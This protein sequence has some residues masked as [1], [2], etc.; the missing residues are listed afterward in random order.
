MQEADKTKEQ[1][2]TEVAQLRQRI[3]ELEQSEIER[4]RVEEALKEKESEENFRALAENAADGI[5]ILTSEGTH[6]YVNRRAAEIV[7]YTVDELLQVGFQNLFPQDERKRLVKM[8][9]KKL[10]RESDTAKYETVIIRKDGKRVPLEVSSAL[11][12]WHGESADIVFSRDITERKQA[13]EALQESE[14]RYRNIFETIPVSIIVLDK[15]GQMVDINPYHLTQ[16]AK[17]QIPKGDFIGK[18]IV[19]HPTI[20]KSG[21]SETYKKVLKGEPFDHKDVYFPLL[22]TG[23]DGYFNVRGVPLLKDD[24]V[25]GAIIIHEDITERKWMEEALRES[26]ERYRTLIDNIDVGINLMDADHS[27]LMANAFMGKMFNKPVSELIG[28]K[29]FLEFEKR[30]AVC[31]HCPGVQTMATGKPAE[32]ET[33][34]VRDD[35]SRFDVR[36]QAFPVTGQDGKTTAFIEIAE[37]I[38]E[39]K[40]M[41]G[42]LQESEEKFRSMFELLPYSTVLLDAEGNI[43]ACNQQFVRFHAT[44]EG[45]EAQVGRNISDFFPP[46]EKSIL[47]V[48]IEKTIKEKKNV[49]GPVEYTMLREDGSRF[50]AEGFSVVMEDET[51]LPK[52]V[53][54]LA[55]DITKRKQAAKALRESE[56]KYRSL[57]ESSADSIYLV[58]RDCTYLFMNKKHLSRLGVKNSRVIGKAYGEFHSPEET[59]DFS[60]KVEKVFKT[61]KSLSYEYRSERDNKYF[62]RTLSPVKASEGGNLSAVTVISKDITELK[63][64]EEMLR[65]RE[66]FNFALFHYNPVET[67]VVDLEGKATGFNLAKE[68]SGDRLPAIGDMMYKDYAGKHEIDMHAELMICIK[69]GK[70]K[71]FPE[72][73]YGD[74]Y[75][76]ITISPFSQGALI[77]SED[78]TERKRAEELLQRERD[79]FFSVLQKAPYGAI[80]IDKEGKGI[81]SN[82]EFTNIT[83]YTLKDVSTLKD[84]FRLA[85]PDKKYRDMVIHTLRGD[86]VQVDGDK[87]YQKEFH[88]AFF[89]TFTMTCKDGT[90]KEI[91]FRPTMLEDGSTIVMLADITE[92][93]RMH[94]LVEAAATEWRTTFDAIS[95]AVC[96]LDQKGSIKRCNNAMLRMIGKPFSEI[97]DR[98]CWEVLHGV[99]NPP[100]G[101]PIVRVQETHHRETDVFSKDNRWFNISVD[102]LMDDEGNLMGGVH[103]MSDITER[104]RVEDELQSSRKQL[105]NLT[106]YLESVREQERTVIARE[107]HDELAQ[108]L[109]ALKMDLSWL[110]NRLP[111]DQNSLLDK[112]KSMNSLIDT[113][114]KTVK[115]ISAELR[116]GILDDLGLVAAIEWQAEEFQERTGIVCHITADP[117]DMIVDQD[118]STA[119]FRIFQETL[120]NVARHA[121]ATRVTVILKE[122]TRALTLSVRD[123]GKG[124][125]EEQ[126]ADS[127]S[128]GLIGMRERV[129]PWGGK[130]TIKGTPGKGTAVLVSV[131][132]EKG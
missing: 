110:D 37:D 132:V 24:V 77:I 40:Q 21:L 27:I 47:F 62:I 75:L 109:T 115:R 60:H 59:K 22:T 3:A 46:E 125:T 41:E 52:A 5:V 38:T 93:K 85:Y 33:K 44:R 82:I 15:D 29:C 112:T 96:L 18:N 11:T 114:I 6:A 19:T 99:S 50:P 120:T 49:I 92:R 57:V 122:K 104:K 53:L 36:L 105:R 9:R 86:A 94:D 106:T 97:V 23:T 58:D 67:I 70:A 118:R 2:A 127:E 17:G 43:Q 102:P 51:G 54:G 108:V 98:A 72:R 30:D 84:W 35:G 129:Y 64:A 39:R 14:K 10:E 88:R 73:R 107:I 121:H 78:I 42:E 116:P 90:I 126:I 68:K 119:I 13:E 80:L 95:D 128:F 91:E 123:N 131:P 7:G 56:E 69:S 16:I 20:V 83:G 34:G 61:G 79:T 111:R 26:E 1:W 101:Y 100:E 65:E 45:A 48:A 32:V 12:T 28:K 74:K 25:I 81:F 89:R 76:F 8:F 31:P 103:I 130:I 117:A 4:K 63:Q 55:Y 87:I 113:T 66:A 124:I 71:A